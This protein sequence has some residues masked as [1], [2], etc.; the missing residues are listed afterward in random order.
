MKCDR[1]LFLEHDERDCDRAT[2]ACCQGTI[3]WVDRHVG[4]Q[5]RTQHDN[6]NKSIMHEPRQVDPAWAPPHGLFWT[7]PLWTTRHDVERDMPLCRATACQSSH[8]SKAA[9]T[10]R[11]SLDVGGAFMAKVGMQGVAECATRLVVVRECR[12]MCSF[13]TLVCSYCSLTLTST[14]CIE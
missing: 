7:R 11:F 5:I 6:Q 4:L 9:S 2:I 10:R 14:V 12:N 3:Q 1:S 13:W 8:L